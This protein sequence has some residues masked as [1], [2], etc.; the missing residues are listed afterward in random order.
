MYFFLII[1]QQL[2][3][4]TLIVLDLLN[5][6]RIHATLVRFALYKWPVEHLHR[7]HTSYGTGDSITM[8]SQWWDRIQNVNFSGLLGNSEINKQSIGHS[9]K[10]SDGRILEQEAVSKPRPCSQSCF[11]LRWQDVTFCITPIW[12][13]RSCKLKSGNLEVLIYK[14][15]VIKIAKL[16]SVFSLRE[17]FPSFQVCKYSITVKY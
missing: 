12:L 11:V 16:S 1:L 6:A 10:I 4:Y 14:K 5:L 17:H 7:I 13:A 8:C 2:K 3:F 15:F 9:K